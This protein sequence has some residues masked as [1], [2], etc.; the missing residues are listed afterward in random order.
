MYR[1]RKTRLSTGSVVPVQ[2]VRFTHS[3]IEPRHVAPR[4]RVQVARRDG[5]ECSRRHRGR[6]R[7]CRF[8][9][10]TQHNQRR[11]AP[12]SGP[13]RLSCLVCASNANSVVFNALRRPREH[14]LF[15]R[16]NRHPAPVLFP[17]F[18]RLRRACDIPPEMIGHTAHRAGACLS[19]VSTSSSSR[20]RQN[21]SNPMRLSR[22]AR[23]RDRVSRGKSRFFFFFFFF[24]FVP[25]A[26]SSLPQRP[27]PPLSSLSQ[28][29]P[30]WPGWA[31]AP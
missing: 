10:R 14:V 26:L 5:Y 31:R 17:S 8:R 7:R 21:R 23:S 27:S 24:F 13:S 1:K 6:R 19:I 30:R 3:V 2:G 15:K 28:T 9:S 4:P 25:S 16:S 18:Q 20:Y 12:T 11:C 22:A 29:R